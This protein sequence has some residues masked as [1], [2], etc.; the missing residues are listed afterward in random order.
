MFILTR[1]CLNHSL[2]FEHP[3]M[4]GI[5]HVRVLP[6][7]RW[8][9]WDF[10]G[11]TQSLEPLCQ[12]IPEHQSYI[13]SPKIVL[14]LPNLLATLCQSIQAHFSYTGSAGIIPGLPIP[15]YPCMIVSQSTGSPRIIQ[16]LAN[17]LGPLCQSIL[18]HRSYAFVTEV[19]AC[20][21]IISCMPS[22]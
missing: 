8:Q 10:P 17:T 20:V 5:I 9:S 18:E 21:P 2:I 12:S 1:D 11:S 7:L 4:S 15:W 16:G 6:G 19:T 3:W 14:G 13:G 22:P